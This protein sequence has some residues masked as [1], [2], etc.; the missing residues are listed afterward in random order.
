MRVDGIGPAPKGSEAVGKCSQL[1]VFVLSNI[2]DENCE[3]PEGTNYQEDI[4]PNH[5]MP[6][7]E[8][9]R[10]SKY[11]FPVF[12]ETRTKDEIIVDEANYVFNRY[13]YNYELYYNYDT[14]LYEFPLKEIVSMMNEGYIVSEVKSILLKKGFKINDENVVQIKP[15]DC[16]DSDNMEDEDYCDDVEDASRPIEMVDTQVSWD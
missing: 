10:L 1:A 13:L 7:F 5:L 4:P 6:N 9:K 3:S 14:D 8:Y 2:L 15:P 16:E 11:D 12:V